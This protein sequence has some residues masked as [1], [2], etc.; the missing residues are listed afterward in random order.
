MATA[1]TGAPGR[2][3]AGSEDLRRWWLWFVVLG[4]L[5]VIVGAVAVGRAFLA[6]IA[7]MVF[8]G[9]LLVIGGAMGAAMAFW[10][11]RGWSGFF[12][13]LLFGL[14]HLVVG[15]LVLVNP[16]AA[17]GALTLLIALLLIFGGVFR[18]IAGISFDF[19]HRGWIV[20][21]G[22]LSLLLGILLISEWPASGLWFIGFCIGLELIFNGAGSIGLGLALRSATSDAGGEPAHSEA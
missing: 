21:L 8:F 1:G 12:L 2:A 18:V 13:N 11:E 20:V 17:A 3:L 22:V 10:R 16:G 6:T 7:S 14:L 9:W 5:L 15:V 4:T 19:P